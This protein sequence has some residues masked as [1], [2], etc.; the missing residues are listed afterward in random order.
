MK[1][2]FDVQFREYEREKEK[3]KKRDNKRDC[4]FMRICICLVVEYLPLQP[5]YLPH[6]ALDLPRGRPEGLAENVKALCITSSNV[7]LT[8]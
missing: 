5:E 3:E 2:F 8:F 7:T 1:E 4:A 6:L